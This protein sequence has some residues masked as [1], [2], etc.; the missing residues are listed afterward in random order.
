MS[1]PTRECWKATWWRPSAEAA[2]TGAAFAIL[3]YLAGPPTLSRALTSQGLDGER[4]SLAVALS[5]VLL[6][7]ALGSALG[8]GLLAWP[9]A[10]GWF[11]I[12]Y[13]APSAFFGLPAPVRGQEL[14]P[15]G[16]ALAILAQGC[17]GVA[18]AGIG[19]AAGRGIRAAGLG[20]AAALRPDRRARAPSVA[21]VAALA[22]LALFGAWNAPGLFL[23]G[24][25]QDSF[26]A[27]PGLATRQVVFRYHSSILGMDEQAIV[28][29]PPGYSAEQRYPVLY[30]LHGSPGSDQ[31]WP[32]QGAGEMVA[33]V[34]ET[35]AVPPML[36]VAPNGDGPKGGS[37]DS[38]ADGYV[39]G[40]RMESSLLK[41]L[42]PAID[43]H[44]SVVADQAHRLLGGLSSGGYGAVNIALRHPGLFAAALDFSGDV[45]P[46]AT[47]FGGD[48]AQRIANDPLVLST[49]PRPLKASA[50]FVGWA[51]DDPYAAENRQ[52]ADQLRSSGYTVSTAVANGGHQWSAWRALLSDSLDQ[53][54]YLVGAVEG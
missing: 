26:D 22:A 17:A 36:V 43:S 23:N 16:V 30:L 54:G 8:S 46:P 50:F 47:A 14:D 44:F 41:E 32:R 18:M 9:A 15:S 11:A 25:W 45:R 19:A 37:H 29:L 13:I 48:E 39:P 34:S 53:M 3:C 27:A 52:L 21:A 12:L 4:T 7:A 35:G 10:A 42:I 40:D 20:I 24:P 49:R 33:A 31:D 28:I 5:A 6:S 38:W 2:L 1:A 51:S